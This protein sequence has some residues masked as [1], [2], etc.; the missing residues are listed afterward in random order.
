[1]QKKLFKGA[2]GVV[3]SFSLSTITLADT[4]PT[5]LNYSF[6]G[7]WYSLQHPGWRTHQ[8]HTQYP[9]VTAKGF[10]GSVFSPKRKQIACIYLM[11]NKKEV[12]LLSQPHD[13]FTIN[14]GVINSHFQKNWIWN[15]KHEDYTCTLP[16]INS[17]EQCHFT[18]EEGA[19]ETTNRP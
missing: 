19:Q 17:I 10:K 3:V 7:Y 13:R 14:K 16:R 11:L 8:T 2:M 4:C 1:M 6:E 15:Q 18:I 12:I 5:K 9:E